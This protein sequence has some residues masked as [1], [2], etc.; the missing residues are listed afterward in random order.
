MRNIKTAISATLCALVY[1]LIDRDPTFAC[2]G[3]VFGTGS[4]M[5]NSWLNGGNRLFGTIIGGFIGMLFYH[6]YI[7]IYPDGD[8]QRLLMLLFLFIG[9]VILIIACQ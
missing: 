8:P 3:A 9:V 4:D 5:E 2:I 7:K 6:I 1:L